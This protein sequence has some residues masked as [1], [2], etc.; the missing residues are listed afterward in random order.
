MSAQP[1]IAER[2]RELE[3]RAGETFEDSPSWHKDLQAILRLREAAV[4]IAGAALA[5]LEHLLPAVDCPWEGDTERPCTPENCT[6]EAARAV[7]ADASR[8]L[9]GVGA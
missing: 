6:V 5:A 9:D 2:W 7:L 4:S 3:R 1:S 8:L